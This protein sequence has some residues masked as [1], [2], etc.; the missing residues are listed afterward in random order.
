MKVI[1]NGFHKNIYIKL[2]GK[3]AWTKNYYITVVL[4]NKML[5]SMINRAI[6]I[7]TLVAKI[8]FGTTCNNFI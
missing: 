8:D 3:L 7:N 2:V 4:G 5:I 6:S 1:C